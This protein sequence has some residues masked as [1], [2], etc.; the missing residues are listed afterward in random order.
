LNCTQYLVVSRTK[1]IGTRTQL[2]VT[3]SNSSAISSAV[4]AGAVSEKC[5]AMSDPMASLSFSSV[6]VGPVATA[7]VV[8]GAKCGMSALVRAHFRHQQPQSMGHPLEY[9]FVYRF[10]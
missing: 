1:L 10:N 3:L 2:F 9:R 5:A 4:A 8:G 7:L 6:L